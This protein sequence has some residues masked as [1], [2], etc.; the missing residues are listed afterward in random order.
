MLEFVHDHLK[1]EKMYQHRVKKN[2]F[3]NKITS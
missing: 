1:T 3:R 2:V